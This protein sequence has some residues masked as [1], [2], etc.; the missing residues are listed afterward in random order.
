[1]KQLQADT[2]LM[3]AQRQMAPGTAVP[4]GT[5]VALICSGSGFLAGYVFGG[6]VH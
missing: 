4:G 6:Y 3:R 2:R 5:G 1:M